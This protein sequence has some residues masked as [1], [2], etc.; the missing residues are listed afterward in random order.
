MV[1]VSIILIRFEKEMN[2][3][4]KT[5]PLITSEQKLK[6]LFLAQVITFLQPPADVTVDG[7]QGLFKKQPATVWVP[8]M[9]IMPVSNDAELNGKS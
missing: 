5:F 8:S 2:L 1:L 7:I 6:H 3:K 4:M 9:L